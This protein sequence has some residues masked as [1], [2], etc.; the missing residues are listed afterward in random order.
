MPSCAKLIAEGEADI[1]NAEYVFTFRARAA[2]AAGLSIQTA[3]NTDCFSSSNSTKKKKLKKGLVV[4][5]LGENLP[6]SPLK[7]HMKQSLGIQG[8]LQTC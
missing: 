3:Q 4:A 2:S 7:L 1:P 8:A 6:R 5:R